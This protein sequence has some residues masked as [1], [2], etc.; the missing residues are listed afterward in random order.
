MNKYEIPESFK[1]MSTEEII[2][3]IYEIAV[4]KEEFEYNI[5][6]MA[7]E[8]IT[9]EKESNIQLRK[10][11]RLAD[12]RYRELFDEK[13][14]ESRRLIEIIGR[15]KEKIYDIGMEIAKRIQAFEDLKSNMGE[16]DEKEKEVIDLIVEVLLDLMQF[17]EYR[18][19]P[20]PL[21]K[22]SK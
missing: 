15:T 1:N 12:E 4:K 3:E 10:D 22:V 9:M 16:E 18:L 21:S 13:V 11:L 7:F 5:R 8:I 2:K 19:I 14:E 17:V 6:K 20:I